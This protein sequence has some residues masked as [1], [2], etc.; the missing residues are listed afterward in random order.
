MNSDPEKFIKNSMEDG[1]DL[2]IDVD[3]E[4]N[5]ADLEAVLAAS[6]SASNKRNNSK[7]YDSTPYHAHH[8]FNEKKNKKKSF[9]L[10]REVN[11]LY[12][13]TVECHRI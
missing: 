1:S 2:E 6:K 12:Q 4:Q 11:Q 13:R 10:G 9:H 8:M 3:F 7:K 5:I